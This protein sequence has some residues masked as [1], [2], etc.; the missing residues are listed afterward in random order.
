[1][2]GPTRL[3]IFLGSFLILFALVASMALVSLMVVDPESR[4]TG[5]GGNAPGQIFQPTDNPQPTDGNSTQEEDGEEEQ[6]RNPCKTGRS[7]TKSSAIVTTIMSLLLWILAVW[8]RQARQTRAFNGWAIAAIVFTLLAI[9]LFFAWYIVDKIC[10]LRVTD[11]DTCREIASNLLATFIGF[12]IPTIGLLAFAIVRKR[13]GHPFLGLWSGAGF[14]FLYITVMALAGHLVAD[15]ICDKYFRQPDIDLGGNGGDDPGDPGDPGS[16]DPGDP[17]QPS[18]TNGPT[19]GPSGPSDP[20]RGGGSTASP[21][22]NQ[23]GGPQL[24][25]VPQISPV[26]LLVIMAV[27]AVVVIIVLALRG[28]PG[29][30][31]MGRA[32]VPAVEDRAQLLALMGRTDLKSRDKVVAAYRTFLSWSAMRGIEKQPTET[33]H[34]HARRAVSELGLPADD[35]MALANA[36]SQTRLGD[37]EPPTSLRQRVINWVRGIDRRAP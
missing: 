18:P 30:G 27:A 16:G 36:Y 7:I 37:V 22:G 9:T 8:W 4:E 2:D 32:A 24:V 31:G 21:G 26:A 5:E 23:G 1:M 34:E 14:V 17:G 12:L 15:D 20:G 11:L 3:R 13:Q 29:A 10:S 19:S 28:G 25:G 35:T 33:P 6:K